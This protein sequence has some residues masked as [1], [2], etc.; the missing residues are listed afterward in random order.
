MSQRLQGT[1]DHLAT[2][3]ADAAIGFCRDA[4]TQA[5][6]LARKSS[7][8]IA[9]NNFESELVEIEHKSGMR[10]NSVATRL[11]DSAARF[12][13]AQEQPRDPVTRA[14]P[15]DPTLLFELQGV[16]R[17]AQACILAKARAADRQISMPGSFES[18]LETCRQLIEAL[19]PLTTNLDGRDA[20]VARAKERAASLLASD[21]VNRE[22]GEKLPR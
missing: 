19:H 17:A 21:D 12:L 7:A 4:E 14:V 11:R 2:L 16:H 15:L 1:R 5:D 9:R 13:R 3:A 22:D 6:A 8:E 20:A 18:L 10:C